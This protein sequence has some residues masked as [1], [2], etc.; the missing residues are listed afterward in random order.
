MI[1]R[2]MRM[3]KKIRRREMGKAVR[4]SKKSRKMRWRKKTRLALRPQG[5]SIANHLKS[6]LLLDWEMS[7]SS[8][9]RTLIMNKKRLRSKI[10]WTMKFQA[11]KTLIMMMSSM[12]KTQKVSSRTG[13]A[14]LSRVDRVLSYS[15][16]N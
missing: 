14:T 15:H 3:T 5:C 16:N 10:K 7:L 9:K 8:R 11:R 4:T 6:K 12:S 13:R 1:M 2:K